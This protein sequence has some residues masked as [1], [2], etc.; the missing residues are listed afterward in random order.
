MQPALARN[1]ILWWTLFDA[2]LFFK[3][4][5]VIVCYF[6]SQ[7]LV[8]DGSFYNV[9]LELERFFGSLSHTQPTRAG[10]MIAAVRSKTATYEFL[11]FK[12]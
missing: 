2:M 6:S 9:S 4:N 12:V 7:N 5:V 3:R 8:I 10:I 11:Q 1:L